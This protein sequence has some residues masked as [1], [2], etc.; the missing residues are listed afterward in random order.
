[1]VLAESGLSKEDATWAWSAGVSYLQHLGLGQISLIYGYEFYTSWGR[2]IK[3]YSGEWTM[4]VGKKAWRL[5]SERLISRRALQTFHHSSDYKSQSPLKRRMYN[6][7]TIIFIVVTQVSFILLGAFPC[8]LPN[9]ALSVS[10]SLHLVSESNTSSIQCEVCA[11]RRLSEKPSWLKP[12][13]KSDQRYLS[14]GS[15]DVRR[16]HSL[17]PSWLSCTLSTVNLHRISRKYI[18]QP[19]FPLCHGLPNPWNPHQLT[20]G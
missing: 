8:L 16:H 9:R 19:S 13:T 20:S 12:M 14:V 18:A 11:Y 1:M 15:F 6:K 5:I 7:S 10:G 3:I 4:N 2:D 17:I